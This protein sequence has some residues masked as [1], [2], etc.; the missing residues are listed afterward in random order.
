MREAVVYSNGAVMLH[1]T[2][3]DKGNQLSYALHAEVF[4]EADGSRQTD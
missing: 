4:K 3:D 1:V 2:F